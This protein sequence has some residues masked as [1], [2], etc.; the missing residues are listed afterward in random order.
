LADNEKTL[1]DSQKSSHSA[2]IRMELRIKD[3]VLIIGQLGPD[4]LMLRNPI[5]HPPTEAEIWMSI[6]GHE[7][8]WPVHLPEGIS[9]A[10]GDTRISP[11]QPVI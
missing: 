11:S 4:F 10:Q 6:D 5:D 2:D 9:T 7:R 1:R 8:L 3:L